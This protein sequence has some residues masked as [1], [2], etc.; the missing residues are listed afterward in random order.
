MSRLKSHFLD[1]FFNPERVAVVGASRNR[2]TTNYWLVAN[3][4]NLKF[5]GKIYPVNPNAEEIMGLK[6]YPSVKSIEDELDLAV[7]SVPASATLDVVK[8]CVAKK[9]KGITII[10]GGFSETGT[11]GKRIQDEIRVLLKE[12][13]IRAIGPNALSPV[14][15]ENNFI[16]GFGAVEEMP[17]GGLSFI[18]QSG[19]YQPR[20]NWLLSDFHLNLNKLIDLGNK[21]DINEV[22]AL[23]Y[24]GEDE[25]TTV[26]ALHLESIAG[27]ARKFI[28]LLKETTRK[29]P[30]IVLKSGR[31]AAGAKAASSHTAAL[32][33]ST[34]ATVDAA[35]KQS[36]AIRVGGLDEFFDL[37]K[38]FEYLPPL[39]NNRVAIATF[40]GGEGVIT[41]D[42]AQL[43]GLALAEPGAEAEKKLRT[44][45]PPWDMPLNPFDLGVATQFH[46]DK[47]AFEI[48]ADAYGSDP[49][50]DCMAIQMT[51]MSRPWLEKPETERDDLG[52]LYSKATKRGKAVVIM[53]MAPS[54]G[55]EEVTRNLE[56][57]RI[58]VYPSAER[59]IRA[60]GALYKYSV[61]RGKG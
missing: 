54:G 22:D 13:G 2:N 57:N 18:F 43:Q 59:A 26:I 5:P 37:A 42:F 6:A 10:A 41:T 36:G 47:D 40:S 53:M 28:R 21:M 49:N 24:L 38:V 25:G 32:M 45:F 33:K 34:D 52:K 44:I 17:R 11:G 58:P 46:R 55:G 30:V 4:V 9:V 23:E 50:V 7:I 51:G 1:L 19:L 3:L 20:L 27:D 12:N 61:L 31:T 16:V 60:L 15:T 29:K 8:D 56:A 35:I 14:N 39:K 48:I